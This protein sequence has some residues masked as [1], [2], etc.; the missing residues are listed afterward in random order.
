VKEALNNIVKHAAATEATIR[1]AVTGREL[2][3]EIEDNG[4][5]LPETVVSAY[6]NGLGNMRER[7]HELRGTCEV[8][9]EP[10]QG[11][12]LVLRFTLPQLERSSL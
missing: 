8:S 10:N 7:L 11:T 12:R 3:I 6:S 4:R 2:Q 5:G 9:S 1:A